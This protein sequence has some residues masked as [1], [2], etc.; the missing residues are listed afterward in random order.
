MVGGRE[1]G[2]LTGWECGLSVAL[3]TDRGGVAIRSEMETCSTFAKLT[4]CLLPGRTSPRSHSLTCWMCLMPRAWATSLSF[5][6]SSLRRAFSSGPVN[7]HPASTQAETKLN[8]YYNPSLLGPW[9]I[10]P[11]FDSCLLSH[12]LF[13]GGHT[14]RFGLVSGGHAIGQGMARARFAATTTIKHNNSV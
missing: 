10:S 9:P 13:L 6:P 12:D 4:R 5:K 2:R 11:C 14:K 1:L 7:L 8:A 3:A